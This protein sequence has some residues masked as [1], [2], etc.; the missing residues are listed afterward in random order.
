MP[1][2]F[3]AVALAGRLPL[4][5]V[6]LW[7]RMAGPQGA[8]G[9]LCVR[10]ADFGNGGNPFVFAIQIASSL[11]SFPPS[12]RMMPRSRSISHLGICTHPLPSI[13]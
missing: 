1:G 7:Q 8:A 4:S 10:C 6:R 2:V 12:T 13:T 11:I 3:G 9:M 5:T